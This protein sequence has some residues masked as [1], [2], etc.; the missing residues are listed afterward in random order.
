MASRQDRR[1]LS[2][3][4]DNPK[5]RAAGKTVLDEDFDCIFPLTYR[6]VTPNW[7]HHFRQISQS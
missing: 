4:Y 7:T 5:L 2:S 3:Y 6:H 1:I